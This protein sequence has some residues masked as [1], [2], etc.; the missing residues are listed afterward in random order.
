MNIAR[1]R[2]SVMNRQ[3]RAAFWFLLPSMSILALFVFWPIADLFWLSFH[4]WSLLDAN[5]AYA[6]LANYVKL[7]H[8]ERFWNAVVRTVYFTAGS[9][10]VGIVLS[11]ALALLANEP[12]KGMSA[13]KAIYFLPVI[14]SF[15]IIS[16]I[17]SFLLDPDIGLLSY[18]LKAAGFPASAWLR[19]TTW[20]MPAVIAVA[21]WKN[22]GFNMVILLA[23]LQSISASLYEAAKIDGAG[24]LQR[25]WSVT[26]PAL[27]Q[28]LLFVVII[29]VI[30]SFQVFDQVYVMTRGGPLNSTETVVY[31][32][33]HHGFELLDMG[34]ASAIAWVLFVVV[35][36]ITLLQL[37]LFRFNETD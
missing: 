4:R 9:V 17:W 3:K 28:T 24:A 6:G 34:Y 13:F 19:S 31:Y 23:G 37:R 20:A 7:V 16:I 5:H 22:V 27:R 12:L 21:I 32:I 11:L 36:L 30:A 2:T 10:P 18:W 25:F 33:Y 1:K 15:A 29:S 8:D 14:S 35:F 26:L